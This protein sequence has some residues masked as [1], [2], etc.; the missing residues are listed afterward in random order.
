MD[1]SISFKRQVRNYGNIYQRIVI[2]DAKN[3]NFNINKI[4]QYV[5]ELLVVTSILTKV[6]KKPKS[7]FMCM[8]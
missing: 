2:S 3:L 8:T 5:D 6:G 7:R 1:F 4:V